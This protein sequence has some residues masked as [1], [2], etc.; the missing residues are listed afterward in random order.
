MFILLDTQFYYCEVQQAEYRWFVLIVSGI[1]VSISHYIALW[2]VW[3]DALL[4]SQHFSAMPGQ[5]LLYWTSAKQRI[6]CLA[7]GHNAVPPVRLEPT[8]HFEWGF[9][10][11]K[12][13]VKKWWWFNKMTWQIHKYD[14]IIEA[15]LSFIE[16]FGIIS[17]GSRGGRGLDPPQ[18]HNW[19]W[20]SLEIQG[21]GPLKN[22]KWK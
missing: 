16:T 11:R 18:N 8:L 1:H 10:I 7:Q 22:H 3:F 14:I 20:V 5:V 13:Y 19:Q 15:L 2:F 9:R 4:L 21:S 17:D 12:F 6:K